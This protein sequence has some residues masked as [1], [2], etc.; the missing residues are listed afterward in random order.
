MPVLHAAVMTM[1]ASMSAPV[2]FEQTLADV[3]YLFTLTGAA[4]GEADIEIPISS[5]QARMRDGDPTF[6][7]VVI[8]DGEQAAAINARQNGTL[9]VDMAYKLHGAF[10]Q[11][12]TIVSALLEDIRV[13]EGTSSSPLTLSGHK[14]ETYN[15][16]AITLT[17]SIYRTI[18]NGKIRHRL[19]EPNINLRPGDTVTIGSD[20]FVAGL[21]SYFIS[22]ES[23]TME[24]AE[25]E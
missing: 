14:T 15:G 7:S 11:R 25:E 12:E 18:L 22:V 23:K 10:I 4:D 6:L 5:F 24:V 9:I 16:L 19:A 8:P 20:T 13:D 3:Y 17:T 21:I 1:A 2:I